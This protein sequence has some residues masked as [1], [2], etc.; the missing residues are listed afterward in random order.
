MPCEVPSQGVKGVQAG[1]GS[2]KKWSVHRG[3]R[4]ELGGA[5]V[6]SVSLLVS[7]QLGIAPR[8]ACGWGREKGDFPELQV[9]E[10]G[11]GEWTGVLGEGGLGCGPTGDREQK[12]GTGAD[13]RPASGS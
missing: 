3:H 9:W 11:Q 10:P 2:C 5:G 6:R 4:E 7:G 13:A 1:E 12:R 8:S